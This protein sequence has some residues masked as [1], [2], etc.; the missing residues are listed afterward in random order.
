M[1]LP[2]FPFYIPGKRK[3]YRKSLRKTQKLRL[4]CKTDQCKKMNDLQQKIWKGAI[5][6]DDANKTL[7]NCAWPKCRTTFNKAQQKFNQTIQE[8]ITRCSNKPLK[9]KRKCFSQ[10]YYKSKDDISAERKLINTY[11]NKHCSKE[12]EKKNL[13]HLYG[14]VKA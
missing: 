7:Y 12:V 11:V 14:A 13:A 8:G 5:D 6:Q 3:S 10:Y 9:A 4:Q 2:D 1:S